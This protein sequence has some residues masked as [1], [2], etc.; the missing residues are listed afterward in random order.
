MKI[1]LTK[2]FLPHIKGVSLY[3]RVVIATKIKPHENLTAETFYTQK[4]PERR[5]YG[6]MHG[7]LLSG[8]QCD[9]LAPIVF[10]DV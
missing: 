5:Y 10:F 2:F 6:M 9:A 4:F 1:K 8:L 7:G 3:C